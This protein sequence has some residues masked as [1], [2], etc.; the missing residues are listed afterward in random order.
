MDGS[1]VKIENVVGTGDFSP[2]NR[3]EEYSIDIE[4]FAEELEPETWSNDGAHPG[5]H[6]RVDDSGK[7]GNSPLTTFYR[8]GKFII[9]AG[10]IEEVHEENERVI[11]EL[12]KTGFIKE[13]E[14]REIPFTISN[15]VCVADMGQPVNLE[16]L[17][18]ALDL[19]KVEYEPEQF[20]ALI[21]RDTVQYECTFLVFANGKVVIPGGT[22]VKKI[23][24]AFEDFSEVVEEWLI[25]EDDS[26]SLTAGL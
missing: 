26:E 5:L 2:V 22:N 25:T 15:I 10:S 12:R 11:A 7:E 8:S 17:A 3:D 16:A 18:F 20:P 9:R 4:V 13:G 6:M 21:Y 1:R 14:E 24:S 19:E 23:R